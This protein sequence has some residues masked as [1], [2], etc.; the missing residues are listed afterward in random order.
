MTSNL[1]F[2]DATAPV[3]KVYAAPDGFERSKFVEIK[4]CRVE[5]LTLKTNDVNTAR[6]SFLINRGTIAVKGTD[7]IMQA[8]EQFEFAAD[9]A[10]M[11]TRQVDATIEDIVFAGIVNNISYDIVQY[12]ISVNNYYTP[13]CFIGHAECVG[14]E[15]FLQE[16]KLFSYFCYDSYLETV[17]EVN[18]KTL[19]ADNYNSSTNSFGGSE[20]WTVESLINYLNSYYRYIY[21]GTILAETSLLGIE[22]QNL[23]ADNIWDL[24]RELLSYGVLFRTTYLFTSDNV[25]TFQLTLINIFDRTA[26]DYNFPCTLSVT[27]STRYNGVVI[28]WN[29]PFHSS[30]ITR[31]NLTLLAPWQSDG[32]MLANYKY[33]LSNNGTRILTYKDL[34]NKQKISGLVT[35]VPPKEGDMLSQQNMYVPDYYLRDYVIAF[36]VQE[37]NIYG[38]SFLINLCDFKF[39]I[40]SITLPLKIFRTSYTTIPVTFVNNAKAPI[41]W[42]CPETEIS[43]RNGVFRIESEIRH[44]FAP[45]NLAA[46]PGYFNSTFSQPQFYIDL[47]VPVVIDARLY[48]ENASFKFKKVWLDSLIFNKTLF[49]DLG[50]LPSFPS[51]DLC[52]FYSDVL[53]SFFSGTRNSAVVSSTDD[54][55]LN[56]IWVNICVDK[57]N[58]VELNVFSHSYSCRYDEVAGTYVFSLNLD[59]FDEQFFI[60]AI[61]KRL[62]MNNLESYV[63][64]SEQPLKIQSSMND[65]FVATVSGQSDD[66]FNTCTLVDLNIPIYSYVLKP[67]ALQTT[68]YLNNTN[69][70]Y[71]RINSYTRKDINVNE[72]QIIVPNYSLDNFIRVKIND[73]DLCYDSY[74]QRWHTLIDEN[75]QNARAWARKNVQ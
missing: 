26:Y 6:I 13:K 7:E 37:L 22:L 23:Q 56:E 39:D 66:Y 55:T 15:S 17:T 19:F 5:E 41:S 52:N 62:S 64:F 18:E 1:V 65:S 28:S 21:K 10:V 14:V 29:S 36:P 42:W 20:I 46:G 59:I 57:I 50:N 4:N 11:I 47:S 70:Q 45:L 60:N 24:L 69:R 35:V 40:A 3:F 53:S 72:T 74:L 33:Q 49:V 9:T 67:T 12:N 2:S 27:K 25:L 43:I 58:E 71:L 34:Y 31:L 30:E 73:E 54:S 8:S 51:P 75:E 38:G 16:V 68:E 44:A 61:K 32:T 63:N 48:S